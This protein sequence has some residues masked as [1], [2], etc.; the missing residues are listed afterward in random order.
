M[1]AWAIGVAK[2]SRLFDHV[3]V[4]TDDEEIADMA[5]QWGAETPFL[6]PVEL[7]DDITPTV[8]VI[9]HATQAC[10]DIGWVVEYTCCIY[11]CV[12]FLQADDLITAFDLVK[13]I[14]VNFAYPVTEYVHPIQR[15]M[16]QISGGQMQFLNPECELRRTQ[17]LEK[18]YHDVGQFYWGKASAWLEQKRMHTD[19]RGIVIP[20]WRV[21]DID[22]YD[23]WRRAE[24]IYNARNQ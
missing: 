15:A 20:N 13:K 19:G 10:I 16:R 9:A 6:R 12:P 21:V 14:D 2:D 4:S 1:I 24:N 8:P 3:L 5:R 22:S 17:D 23:D 7:A 11:P 18:Y